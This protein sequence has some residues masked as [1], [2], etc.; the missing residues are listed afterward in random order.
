MATYIYE[1]YLLPLSE[2]RKAELDILALVDIVYI[3][4]GVPMVYGDY[5]AHY[6]NKGEAYIL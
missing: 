4:Y 6:D 5:E 3:Y 2:Y 1:R